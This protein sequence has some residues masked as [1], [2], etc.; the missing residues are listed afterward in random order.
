MED[1]FFINEQRGRA[2]PIVDGATPEV[3]VLITKRM[4]PE[5]ALMCKPVSNIPHG[6]SFSS[7]FQIFALSS[8]PD[9]L[10]SC[11]V[12]QKNKMK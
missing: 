9:F 2:Q 8:V 4:Q 3:V 11:T 6:F 10:P 5:Q 1:I 12:T 7:C